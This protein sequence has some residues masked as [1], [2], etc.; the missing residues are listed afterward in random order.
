MR[1]MSITV[2]AKKDGGDWKI[3]NDLGL[4]LSMAPPLYDDIVPQ[5]GNEPPPSYDTLRFKQM[6]N[7]QEDSI[8]T[9]EC[10]TVACIEALNPSTGYADDVLCRK[11]PGPCGASSNE[12]AFSHQKTKTKNKECPVEKNSNNDVRNV[13]CSENFLNSNLYDIKTCA[14]VKTDGREIDDDENITRTAETEIS[15]SNKMCSHAS[16]QCSM[17][18]GFASMESNSSRGSSSECS[19]RHDG[20]DHACMEDQEDIDER[21]LLVC[22]KKPA[23]GERDAD[24]QFIDEL[25]E[26]SNVIN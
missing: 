1:S 25:N 26:N 15:T 17:E 19:P 11:I 14:G 3:T 6:T 24:I 5:E 16:S 10:I 18:T 7:S 23:S 2:S 12:T 21:S 4:T 20:N 8:G 22:Y 9:N 13:S